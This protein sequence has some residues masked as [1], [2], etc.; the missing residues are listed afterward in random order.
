[1][2]SLGGTQ[3]AEYEVLSSLAGYGVRAAGV[4]GLLTDAQVVAATSAETLSANLD[5]FPPTAHAEL[6]F[7]ALNAQLALARGD[8]LGDYSDVRIAA[9]TSVQGVSLLTAAADESDLTHLGPHI[10]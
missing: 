9:A 10:V 8:A 5:T 4:E 6:E 3:H 2:T 7:Q 1:M